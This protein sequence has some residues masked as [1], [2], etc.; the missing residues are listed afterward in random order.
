ML[1][2]HSV[3]GGAGLANGDVADDAA[4][5]GEG[6]VEAG[7]TADGYELADFHTG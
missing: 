2:A 5:I 7:G 4:G 6:Y 1:F 3:T